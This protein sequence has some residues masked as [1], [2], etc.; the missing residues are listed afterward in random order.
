MMTRFWPAAAVAIVLASGACG[1]DTR[2]TGA[3]D[4]TG[5][6]TVP[7]TNVSVSEIRLG[8]AV[9]GDK[10]VAE[11]TDDFRTTETI[12]ASVATA[13]I[14]P[15]ATLSARWTF[16]DGQVV[17]EDTQTIAPNGPAYT[18]FH[19][20]NPSGWPTGDYKVE[21]FLNGQSVGSKDFEI[22]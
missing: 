21:F 4:G 1:N 6:A 2:D 9:G 5:T 19:I 11:E 16:Q 7:A 20:S 3:A 17:S 22:K 15:N 12:Y 14:S 8:N 10:R 18:E 13:G